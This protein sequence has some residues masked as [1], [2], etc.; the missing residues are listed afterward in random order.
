VLDF[1]STLVAND[2][3]MGTTARQII[4]GGETLHYTMHMSMTTVPDMTMHLDAGLVRFVDKQQLLRRLDARRAEF[5]TQLARIP[6]DAPTVPN[7]IGAWSV[8]DLL[9][10]LIAHEQRVL[11][12]LGAAR[13][14]KRPPPLRESND[15]F[16]A[17][18]VAARQNQSLTEVRAAWDASFAQVLA[19][20]QALSDADFEPF[21]PVCELLEDTIDGALGNNT[22]GH[23]AEHLPALAELVPGLAA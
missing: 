19:A 23:Y 13:R 17:E 20:V 14:G 3:R 2:A 21:G 4:L 7:K 15:A 12:E 16:N 10:H 6:P 11:A 5:L 8:R 18:A 1:K 9:A 22:Y